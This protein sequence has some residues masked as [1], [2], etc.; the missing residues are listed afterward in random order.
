MGLK[1]STPTPA[2]AFSSL[3][4]SLPHQIAI[5]RLQLSLFLKVRL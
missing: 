4:Q 1:S 5:P 2:N 3:V